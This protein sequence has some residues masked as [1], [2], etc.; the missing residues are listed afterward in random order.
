MSDANKNSDWTIEKARELYRTNQWSDGYYGINESGNVSVFP[1]C[2][3]TNQIDLKVLMDELQKRNIQ[4]PVL[5]RFLDIL[6]DRIKK[7]VE[8]FEQA[9]K[10]YDYSGEYCPVYPI[11]VNQQ[12][13]AVEAMIETNGGTNLGLEAGSKA[14]LIAALALA[15]ETMLII[16][17]GYKDTD[18]I[19]T[20]MYGSRIG[21]KPILVVE[22]ISEIKEVIEI[23]SGVEKMPKLG[24]RV[25]LS[26]RSEGRW[27][28]TSGEQS[29]F[30]LRISE[31]VRAITLLKEAGKLDALNLLH[32]HIGSQIPDIQI[33]KEAMTEIARIYV[34]LRKDGIN[35]E[36]IDVGGGLGIN[37]AGSN[38]SSDYCINYSIADYA[39]DI[40]YALKTVCK[41]ENLPEPRLI[42]ESGRALTA[43][44]S[45]LVTNAVDFS[46]P[47]VD[48]LPSRI[49]PEF[50]MLEDMLGIN[51]NLTHNNCRGFYHDIV[52]IYKQAVEG[53][54]VGIISLEERSEIESL[55]WESMRKIRVIAEQHGLRHREFDQLNRQLA[56]TYILN[57]S[58]FQSVPDCWAIE[59]IFPILPIHR[60]DEEPDTNC[61]LADLTCDSDGCVVRY[62][63]SGGVDETIPLHSPREGEPYYIGFFLVGAYQ[64]VLG[65]YHNLFGATNAVHI[66]LDAEST[67]GYK[68]TH[69]IKGE[70]IEEILGYFE[71]KAGHLIESLRHS[72]ESSVDRGAI[73]VEEGVRFMTHFERAFTES[74]YLND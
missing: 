62:L 44:Y 21:K 6:S 5:I 9:R 11:K 51:R 32:F 59:Q 13:L 2:D 64:E 56:P 49:N 10:T 26:T 52:Y 43:H 16:C 31:V 1:T 19:K 20:A 73:S 7:L 45:V 30:G 41:S 3:V 34:A 61:V 47:N 8:C 35:I 74:P 53:F 33:I 55:Y 46:R 65:D 48:V 29:K 69:R 15:S 27:A 22:K 63:D 54:R 58:L 37:Y 60:L 23:A 25:K 38:D 70:T 18:Y 57:F 24:V 71:Y 14:E 4:P 50:K 39:E 72:M 40:V 17:N 42:T 67:G 36:Y 28:E 68:I 12:R 66:S